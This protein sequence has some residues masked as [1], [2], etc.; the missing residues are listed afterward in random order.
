MAMCANRHYQL[1]LMCSIIM[2]WSSVTFQDRGGQFCRSFR[3]YSQPKG[4]CSD[5]QTDDAFE[6]SSRISSVT[7]MDPTPT[8]PPSRA[9][10]GKSHAANSS[11]AH[12][13]ACM[14]T[15][16]HAHPRGKP[17]RQ[18]QRLA[19]LRPRMRRDHTCSLCFTR[20]H[21]CSSTSTG[22]CHYKKCGFT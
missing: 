17:R 21:A 10:A 3:L 18:R 22:R 12:S 4:Q 19:R 15:L 20:P 1:L 11:L 7:R 13:H 8:P 16:R 14:E 6:R 9:P 2:S 5:V